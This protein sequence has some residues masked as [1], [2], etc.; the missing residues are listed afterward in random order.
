MY[1]KVEINLTNSTTFN[2]E[3]PNIPTNVGIVWK[4]KNTETQM[5]LNI[6]NTTTFNDGGDD[7]GK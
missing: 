4:K 5:I 1:N 7:N 2:A 3:M 6:K